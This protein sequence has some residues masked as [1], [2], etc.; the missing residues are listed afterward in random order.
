[1][2]SE[3]TLRISS[4][5]QREEFRPGFL[6][7]FTNPFYHSRKGLYQNIRSLAPCIKGRVL[8]VGCGSKPYKSLFS[9]SDYIGLEISGGYPGADCYY[10][11][12]NFP[13]LDCD[14]DSVLTSQVL[15]HVFN[16]EIF[17]YEVNRVLKCG[18]VLL[19][20]VPFTWDEHEQP[21]DYA[22]YSSFGLRYLLEQKGFVII[23]HRKSMDDIRV[24]F[25]LINTYIFKKTKT[26]NGSLNFIV[27]L[28]LIAPFNVLGE[29]MSR[30]LPANKDLYL[31][32]I[33]LARKNQDIRTQKVE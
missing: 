21:F 6:G 28:F 20:T 25:Q 23:E 5:I 4:I 7:I 19:L 16:P 29:I 12:K 24:I 26:N 33:I 9:V 13:F 2:K 3:F 10:N 8:D 14:F 17:L 18:G 27:T 11:G 31:D 30:I 1:M 32:N 22:R 15:E